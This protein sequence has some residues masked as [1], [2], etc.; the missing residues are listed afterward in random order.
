METYFET[1]F[2]NSATYWEQTRQTSIGFTFFISVSGSLAK[3][4]ASL[5]I[6]QTVRQKAVMHHNID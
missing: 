6:D 5:A 4:E 1:S 2:L 3:K